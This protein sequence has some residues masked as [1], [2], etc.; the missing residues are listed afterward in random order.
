MAP[1]EAAPTTAPFG[2]RHPGLL[3]EDVINPQRLPTS[4]GQRLLPPRLPAEA[5]VVPAEAQVVPVVE[6]VKPRVSGCAGGN[7][8][9]DGW[10]KPES[11]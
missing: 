4:P 6:P 7:I 3:A 2:A 10:F 1:T 8:R 5:Q 11:L 9:I